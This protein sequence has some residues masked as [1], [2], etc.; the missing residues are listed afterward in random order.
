M[1]LGLP[2][3]ATGAK[4]RWERHLDLYTL[5]PEQRY[6]NCGK[7]NMMQKTDLHRR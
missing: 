5:R 6:G 2:P 7:A 4:E 3:T 1:S